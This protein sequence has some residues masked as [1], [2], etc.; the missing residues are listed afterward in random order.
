[1][2]SQAAIELAR[3]TPV[4]LGSQWSAGYPL[5]MRRARRLAAGGRQDPEDLISQATIKVLNYLDHQREAEN[6]IGLMLVSLLQVH[7][8]SRRSSANRIFALS[9]E[10]S[11]DVDLFLD[12]TCEPCAERN[13]IAKETLGDIFDCLASLPPPAQQ[14]F[15]LRF[16]CDLSYGEISEVMEITEACARQKVKKLR[17]KLQAWVEN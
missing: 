17:E 9:D 3:S 2:T 5:L 13:Y 8:D 16:V 10:L 4:D 6:F 7:L 12:V 15:H 1:M 14:L 11:D